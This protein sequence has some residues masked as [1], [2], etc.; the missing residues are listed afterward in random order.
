MIIVRLST[1][2]YGAYVEYLCVVRNDTVFLMSK[3][4][5]DYNNTCSSSTQIYFNQVDILQHIED[6]LVPNFNIN[7]KWLW[8][9]KDDFVSKGGFHPRSIP[10]TS[11]FF[12]KK[13]DPQSCDQVLTRNDV[14]S[15]FFQVTLDQY[16]LYHGTSVEN[17]E[18]ILS[19]G[20]SE[21]YGMLGNA[22]Y[23]GTF[24]KATRYAA[25][26]QDYSF[27]DRGTIF[28]CLAFRKKNNESRE[29]HFPRDAHEC[30]CDLCKKEQSGFEKI[31]DHAST[32][33]L[34][35]DFA[36]VQVSTEPFA[37][38]KDKSPKFLCT[39]AEWAFKADDV[40]ISGYLELDIDSIDKPHHN[41]FQRNAKMKWPK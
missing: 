34:L 22:V 29:I 28:R 15:S 19:C 13:I 6:T 2:R 35:G 12:D 33:K 16:S 40:F 24:H 1:S 23:L 17:I 10:N 7:L 32:W 37:F 14:I 31:C 25:R 27:R 21:T 36:S 38:K 20:L 41:P 5:Y 4:E 18:T 11:L 8:L 26:R 30:N 3:N 9:V 39:N